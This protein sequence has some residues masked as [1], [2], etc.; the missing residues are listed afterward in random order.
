MIRVT[1]TKLLSSN[2]IR[3]LSTTRPNLN[4]I[5]DLYLKELNSVKNGLDMSKITSPKGNVLEWKNLTKPIIPNIE[6]KDD[7]ILN[8]YINSK[9]STLENS[10]NTQNNTTQQEVE[11][12]WLVIDDIQGDIAETKH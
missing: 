7:S 3:L 6:G 1:A 8:D 12:D 4:L 11:E 9:V 10:E 2:S 5:Q